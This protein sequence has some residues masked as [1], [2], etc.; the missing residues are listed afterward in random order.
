MARYTDQAPTQPKQSATTAEKQL[1]VRFIKRKLVEGI[2]GLSCTEIYRRIAADN[3]PKQVILGPKSV[4]WV[5][6][7]VLQWANDRIAESRA[8][9]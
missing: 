1:A 3:F 2:T 4:V 9:V 5:E 8:V 7:E 6:S